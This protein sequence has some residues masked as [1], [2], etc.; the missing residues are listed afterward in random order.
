MANFLDRAA[1]KTILKT[2]T[3][4]R[5]INSQAGERPLA[6]YRAQ[7]NAGTGWKPPFWL[8]AAHNAV[9]AAAVEAFGGWMMQ[10]VK[11]GIVAVFSDA[12]AAL[13]AALHAVHAFDLAREMVILPATR[14]AVVG[15]LVSVI[16][17]PIRA[18]SGATVARAEKLLARVPDGQVVVETAFLSSL[19]PPMKYGDIEISQAKKGKIP[20]LGAV[21]TVTLKPIGLSDEL[22]EEMEVVDAELR[23]RGR[24]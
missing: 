23:A 10:E 20:G 16:E 5:K 13:R 8:M 21:E 18:V 22:G 9:H 2:A 3:A 17:R 12:N 15:G 6:V 14:V 7:G 19:K 11:D 24:R 4:V 1:L